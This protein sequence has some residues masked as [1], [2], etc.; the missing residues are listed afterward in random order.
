[1]PSSSRRYPFAG[2]QVDRELG[3]E[4][5]SVEG[6]SKTVDGVR[7]LNHVSFRVNRE[8]KIVFLGENEVAATAPVQDSDG[9][10][11]AGRRQ[12]QMGGQFPNLILSKGKQRVL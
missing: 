8:D 4:V 10:T 5:L 1:M 9:G 3:K 11:P 6:L 2:F 12:F 7:V